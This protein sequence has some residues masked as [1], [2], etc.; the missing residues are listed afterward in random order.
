[1]FEILHVGRKL[2]YNMY[3][4]IKT[5]ASGNFVVKVH[6]LSSI[7]AVFILLCR[8]FHFLDSGTTKFLGYL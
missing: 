5:V 4:I 7:E 3:N 6:M 1:M 8:Y 2:T